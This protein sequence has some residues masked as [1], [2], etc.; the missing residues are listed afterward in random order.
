MTNTVPGR[1]RPLRLFACALLL[2]AG[3][4]AACGGGE[5][6]SATQSNA[7][8]SADNSS[9]AASTKSG[10]DPASLDAE[11][12]RLEKQAGKNPGNPE[13]LAELARAY[14]SRGNAHRAAGRLREAMDDYRSA[15]SKDPDNEEALKNAADIAPQVE[16]TPT[17]EYGEPAPLPISP[18]VTGAEEKPS[19][20]PTPKKQ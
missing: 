20:T 3:F 14:V 12:E 2:A 19:P 6:N 16:G 10:G 7:S 8:A 1:A 4:S 15:Q 5:S 13:T 11:V 18:N 17:G 9:V